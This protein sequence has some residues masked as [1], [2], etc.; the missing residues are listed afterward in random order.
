MAKARRGEALPE[1]PKTG[2]VG[3]SFPKFQ[4]AETVLGDRAFVADLQREGLLHGALVFSPHARAK[5]KRIDVSQAA[6]MPGVRVVATAKDVPGERWYG[7]LYNDWPGLVAVGEEVRCVGD[8][9]A[10]VAADDPRLARAAAAK[11]KVEYEVLPAVLDP[12]DA[13]KPGAPRVNP[14]HDNLL[15]KS[16]IKRGDA[17][18]AL[19]A[20]AHVVSG[21]YQTQRIEHLFLE[22]E[23]CLAEPTK[24]GVK[25]YSQGQ[26]IF[27]DRRQVSRFLGL[28]EEQVEVELVPN[29]GA[30]GGK[31][32]M[33]VQS[34]TALLCHLTRRPV[35]VEL[36]RDESVR[37]HPKRHPITLEYQMGC[38]AEGRLTAIK[39][40]LIGD[41]G[42]Y[43]SVGGKV[44]ER[45]AG[46][47]CG[48]YRVPNVDVEAIAAYTNN[49]PCGAMRGFGANQA[50]F[51][52]EGCLEQLAKKVGLDGYQIRSNATCSRWATSSAPARCWRSRSACARRSRR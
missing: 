42:A 46:H 36:N 30:F 37:V 25:F 35:R 13:V 17:D 52:V 48:P 47:S 33:S 45:A 50:S 10:A 12:R 2:G 49:P 16:V 15:Q 27:D 6:A 11:V 44:L 9:V 34:Q 24:D 19:K 29:G 39:A 43:A 5:V 7:L 38:D 20:S 21:T 18:Q 40:R 51:A 3:A 8:V 23:C 32:D 26:G 14:A 41:S 4:G 1:L 28:A 31:E 22:P